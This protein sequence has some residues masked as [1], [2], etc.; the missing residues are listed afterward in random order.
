[1]AVLAAV[2]LTGNHQLVPL[3]EAELALE[4]LALTHIQAALAQMDTFLG[5]AASRELEVLSPLAATQVAAVLL[6]VK[7]Q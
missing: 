7:L 2:Q 6:A 4:L 1:M 5:M 3:A